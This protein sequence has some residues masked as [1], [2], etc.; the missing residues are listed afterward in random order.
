MVT[1]DRI[2][3]TGLLRRKPWKRGFFYA[4]IRQSSLRRSGSVEAFGSPGLRFLAL[5]VW[6]QLQLAGTDSTA[7]G[8]DNEAALTIVSAAPLG[9]GGNSVSVACETGD[10]TTTADMN[11]TLVRVDALN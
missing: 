8:T 7:P 5:P 6:E 10:T 3:L 9:G 1:L 2:R 4:S 11:L